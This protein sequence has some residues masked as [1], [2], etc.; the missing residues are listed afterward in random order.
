LS[1]ASEGG[2]GTSRGRLVQPL[3]QQHA[4]SHGYPQRAHRAPRARVA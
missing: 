1:A 2:T 4:N 3:T